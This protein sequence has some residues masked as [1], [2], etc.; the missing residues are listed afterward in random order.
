MSLQANDDVPKDAIAAT[1]P[2]DK[3]QPPTSALEQ[4]GALPAPAGPSVAR[5]STSSSVGR[6]LLKRLASHSSSRSKDDPDATLANDQ[7]AADL[8]LAKRRTSQSSVSSHGH[9]GLTKAELAELSKPKGKYKSGVR[10]DPHHVP[11]PFME[12]SASSTQGEGAVAL[13]EGLNA[14]AMLSSA[15]T[16]AAK[17][18]S[19]NRSLAEPIFAPTAGETSASANGL[20]AASVVP[21][22]DQT[23]AAITQSGV[24]AGILTER[25]T[26]PK[27]AS[28]PSQKSRSPTETSAP[29]SPNANLVRS[30]AEQQ[31]VA[32]AAQRVL[33]AA[34]KQARAVQ[35]K[36][37][38]SV[39]PSPQ[40]QPLPT[41]SAM[42]GAEV[43]GKAS[44]A[45]GDKKAPSDAVFGQDSKSAAKDR[46]SRGKSFMGT[47]KDKSSKK[48][49]SRRVSL[50]G[51]GATDG[52]SP[53]APPDA[54]LGSQPG[55]VG[56]RRRYQDT[57]DL[58]L[59][60]YELA[61]EALANGLPQPPFARASRSGSSTPRSVSQTNPNGDSRRRSYHSTGGGSDQFLSS[62]QTSL[63]NLMMQP[64]TQ[65][66]PDKRSREGTASGLSVSPKSTPS[67]SVPAS[68]P[69]APGDVMRPDMSHF[70]VASPYM[71]QAT[72]L[73]PSDMLTGLSG[74]PYPALASR[75]IRDPLDGID[76]LDPFGIP[77]SHESPFDATSA[78]VNRT[79]V[80]HTPT[81]VA[82]SRNQVGSPPGRKSVLQ[83]KMYDPET[84]LQGLTKMPRGKRVTPFG[85]RASSR[86]PSPSP[87]F[88]NLKEASKA[89]PT[90]STAEEERVA[91][92]DAAQRCPAKTADRE[93]VTQ[94]STGTKAKVPSSPEPPAMPKSDTVGAV[95]E[96]NKGCGDPGSASPQSALGCGE[97]SPEPTPASGTVKKA[98]HT[99]PPHSDASVTNG[100]ASA[101]EA[102]AGS[103]KAPDALS[104]HSSK[105]SHRLSALFGL[106]KK[107]TS[108]EEDQLKQPLERGKAAPNV[109]GSSSEVAKPPG[110]AHTISVGTSRSTLPKPPASASAV[111]ERRSL[112]PVSSQLAPNEADAPQAQVPTDAPESKPMIQLFPS[113]QTKPTAVP[114]P[115]TKDHELA[116]GAP[117]IASSERPSSGKLSQSSSPSTAFESRKSFGKASD[118]T[119]DHSA[120]G[121]S[122]SASGGGNIRRFLRRLSSFG[123]SS[124]AS[125]D[126]GFTKRKSPKPNFPSASTM[127]K[128]DREKLASAVIPPAA[129][130]T[131]PRPA[132]PDASGG[133][134]LATTESD[135]AP[136]GKSQL[137]ARPATESTE[138]TDG[139]T[140]S[141]SPSYQTAEVGDAQFELVTRPRLV[142]STHKAVDDSKTLTTAAEVQDKDERRIESEAA[143]INPSMAK[144]GF[145]T[146]S[147]YIF[148]TAPSQPQEGGVA[149]AP[150]LTL[151]VRRPRDR[152]HNSSSTRSD[153]HTPSSEDSAFLSSGN[154]YLGKGSGD[155]VA[156]TPSGNAANESEEVITPASSARSLASPLAFDKAPFKQPDQL[157][158]TPA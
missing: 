157:A 21:T 122:S 70:S 43:A 10:W 63:A 136:S 45:G 66:H 1:K 34:R 74:S 98:V 102:K 114:L 26:S 13:Q 123:A 103:R 151:D 158:P 55:S 62:S 140:R 9:R 78:Y 132:N 16:A 104:P 33:E 41:L 96:G 88:T 54:N 65:I 89:Q 120:A 48:S 148:S 30:P 113:P 107:Q 109:R 12:V 25:E 146:K 131:E 53:T 64:M 57:R 40:T 118:T 124:P 24:T 142:Q 134:A 71:T 28:P 68:P 77:L 27:T 100:Q 116:P 144:S 119:T 105:S 137:T 32:E 147:A 44:D 125:S 31:M 7:A 126:N 56:R 11:E 73:M 3:L 90:T 18:Y 145:G 108:K 99:A 19:E 14:N 8:A 47:I 111:L 5:R 86:V 121:S 23:L 153:S 51:A 155:V 50:S 39:P 84:E 117:A 58:D 156:K 139:K 46:A 38:L 72:A 135:V 154:S 130:A 35:S 60:A 97:P 110:T 93:T 83:M 94:A 52:A 112:P 59:L 76:N 91:S 138:E 20:V 143:V 69:M 149:A 127:P 22:V 4:E 101:S 128:F 129:A 80:Y 17:S 2:S 15:S 75:K 85:S 133:V 37:G 152:S 115:T 79:H 81:Q 87:S 61:A 106:G 150:E 42:S 49:R 95:A 29:S 36:K 82:H 141:A 92:A 6:G 67:S